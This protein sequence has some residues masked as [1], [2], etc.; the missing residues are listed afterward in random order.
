MHAFIMENV[1]N[2]LC[3]YSKIARSGLKMH[4]VQHVYSVIEKEPGVLLHN[5][6]RNN[7]ME[8]NLYVMDALCTVSVVTLIHSLYY[9][10]SVMDCQASPLWSGK[11]VIAK[12]ELCADPC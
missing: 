7:I 9:H 3:M 10:E 8:K 2:V 5:V 12:Y 11:H 4:S 6:L 1:H